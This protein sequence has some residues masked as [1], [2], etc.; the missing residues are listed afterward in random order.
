MQTTHCHHDR[1][2]VGRDDADTCDRHVCFI[3]PTE[4]DVQSKTCRCTLEKPATFE[5]IQMKDAAICLET[6]PL[7]KRI[8]TRLTSVL[9]SWVFSLSHAAASYHIQWT[10]NKMTISNICHY[11]IGQSYLWERVTVRARKICDAN[12]LTDVYQYIDRIAILAIPYFIARQECLPSFHHYVCLIPSSIYI[13]SLLFAV[14]PS[15]NTR[16]GHGYLRGDSLNKHVDRS[17]YRK[18]LSH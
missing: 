1:R 17:V 5:A 7:P 14:A 9:T 11:P 3:Y 15:V 6:D 16:Y 4:Q 18:C 8:V 10:K 12:I 2:C 13:F